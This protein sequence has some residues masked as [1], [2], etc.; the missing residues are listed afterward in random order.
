MERILDACWVQMSRVDGLRGI[1]RKW[2]VQ[3]K[4]RCAS[5]TPVERRCSVIVQKAAGVSSHMPVIQVPPSLSSFV[6]L[7]TSNLKNHSYLALCGQWLSKV[8]PLT[9]FLGS[10]KCIWPFPI[11]TG[12]QHSTPFG[13]RDVCVVAKLDVVYLTA[14]CSTAC[15]ATERFCGI[16][17]GIFW[18]VA[19]LEAPWVWLMKTEG[20]LRRGRCLHCL[21]WV[22]GAKGPFWP[23]W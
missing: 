4:D 1:E 8:V 2:G 10:R 21:P 12:F 3:D 9:A 11:K 22:S 18:N 15:H 14:G 5:D 23:G 6:Q 20:R 17:I 16:G 19:K 13:P 7:P